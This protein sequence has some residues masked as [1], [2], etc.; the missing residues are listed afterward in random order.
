MS[1]IKLIQG[2]MSYFLLALATDSTPLQKGTDAGVHLGF[3]RSAVLP[4]QPVL[5]F[6]SRDARRL[7][8][9]LEPDKLQIDS[10]C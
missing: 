7:A 2:S 1:N 6:T 8:P 4:D 3:S 5:F 10:V 9:Q